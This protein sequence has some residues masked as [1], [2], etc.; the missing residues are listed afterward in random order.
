[1]KLRINQEIVN[2][3][4]FTISD[5]NAENNLPSVLE[6]LCTGEQTKLGVVIDATESER[7][8]LA[9]WITRDRNYKQ[10]VVIA[11]CRDDNDKASVRSVYNYIAKCNRLLAKLNNN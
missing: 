9:H 11:E 8:E 3:L 2:E 10:E 7:V 4:N 5:L 6:K 1:M